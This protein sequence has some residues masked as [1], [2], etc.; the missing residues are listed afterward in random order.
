MKKALQ[1]LLLILAL[2]F[3]TANFQVDL[4]AQVS[5]KEYLDMKLDKNLVFCQGNEEI[6]PYYI[7]KSYVSNADY[8]IYLAWIY[9][10]SYNPLLSFVNGLPNL[11][12]R[13]IEIDYEDPEFLN[14]LVQE[15]EFLRDYMFNLEYAHYPV[16]GLRWDQIHGLMHWLTDRYNITNLAME[17][18]IYFPEDEFQDNV[19]TTETLLT[20]W[21]TPIWNRMIPDENGEARNVT[22]EDQLLRPAFRLPTSG[23]LKFA[24]DQDI[25]GEIP[26]PGKKT[27]MK[28][29]NEQETYVMSLDKEGTLTIGINEYTWDE[30]NTVRIAMKNQEVEMKPKP[31]L[32][33]NLDAKIR[34]TVNDPTSFYRMMHFREF[35]H[36]ILEVQEDENWM[37]YEWI[38][39]PDS[40]GRCQFFIGGESREGEPLLYSFG[41][42]KE[43]IDPLYPFKLKEFDGE[44][45]ID[46]ILV[47][48]PHEGNRWV[49]PAR[50]KYTPNED[51]IICDTWHQDDYNYDNQDRYI[52]TIA[53][54]DIAKKAAE[55]YFYYDHASNSVLTKKGEKYPVFRYAVSAI[56]KK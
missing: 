47:P 37:E 53:R 48:D 38:C 16:I 50:M 54:A 46:Q 45:Y 28:F 43:Y 5:K 36:Q 6:P 44:F 21:H 40:T 20:E 12:D 35:D 15:D 55:G 11:H 39:S 8:I 41:G 29:L 4:N 33:W 19:F 32:E 42:V 26:K 1:F 49:M 23:E 31:G 25:T 3:V 22:W 14:H 34:E 18:L 10:V 30:D 13:R 27:F 7:S 2:Q 56:K 52:R 51:S 9:R 17:D 24:F